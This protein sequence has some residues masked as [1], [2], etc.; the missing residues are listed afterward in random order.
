M[1]FTIMLMPADVE[2]PP[3]AY[4]AAI[5]AAAATNGGRINP[6]GVVRLADG[7]EFVVDRN[8]F[9]PKRLSPGVCRVVFDAALRTNTYVETAGF[10]VEPLKVNGSTLQIPPDLGPAVVV[11]DAGALCAKLQGRLARWNGEM[12]LMRAEGVVGR[13]DVLPEPP[14]APGAE[15]RV[16]SDASGIAA[17]CESGER[18]M[19]DRLGWRLVRAM[20]TRNA[21]WGVVWRADIAPDADPSTWMRESCWQPRRAAA[22]GSITVSVRPLR[23]FDKSQSIEPLPAE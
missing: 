22:R 20:V 23:M 2:A 14:A 8:D 17:K 10:D 16:A 19:A 21:D 12:T 3:P 11:A 7:G 9:W 18:Q 1:P 5:E 6:A 15:A 4:A 13:D